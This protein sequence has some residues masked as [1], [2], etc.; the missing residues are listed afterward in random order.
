MNESTSVNI[1]LQELSVMI[2]DLDNDL[3]NY[4][5]KTSP[6]I[7]SM[8]GFDVGNGMI[9]CDIGGLL[10]ET[11]YYWYVNVTDGVHWTHCSF[12]FETE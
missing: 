3:M 12:W 4:T 8:Y 2:T 6:N 1:S 11:R 7:G 10:P 5:I 9:T